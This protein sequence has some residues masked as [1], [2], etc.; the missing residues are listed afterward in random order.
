[1]IQALIRVLIILEAKLRKHTKKTSKNKILS[2]MPNIM[3]NIYICI[4]TFVKYLLNASLYCWK[5]IFL[6]QN[7]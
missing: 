4:R 5:L 6:V 3:K 7:F 2:T 1:M